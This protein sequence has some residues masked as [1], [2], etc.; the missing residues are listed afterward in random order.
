MRAASGELWSQLLFASGCT[1]AFVCREEYATW[2]SMIVTQYGR[3]P[4]Q[5]G[6]PSQVSLA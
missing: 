3:L 5:T 4:G 1:T 2:A 6:P